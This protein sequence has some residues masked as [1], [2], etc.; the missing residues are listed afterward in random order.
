MAKELVLVWIE[1]SVKFWKG[2]WMDNFTLTR[3]LC[4]GM[5]RMRWSSLLKLN[6]C[7]NTKM[8]IIMNDN[9]G[10][11]TERYWVLCSRV[12]KRCVC[13]VALNDSNAWFG[14][15][16]WF[17]YIAII[18]EEFAYLVCLNSSYYLQN[19]NICT[20]SMSKVCW[21]PLK[22]TRKNEHEFNKNKD[23]TTKMLGPMLN[24]TLNWQLFLGIFVPVLLYIE[25]TFT[26]DRF[27]LHCYSVLFG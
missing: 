11:N 26:G 8:I 20:T 9:F 16:Y 5:K 7:I 19:S 14:L 6:L 13:L 17:T 23:Q 1:L 3:Q 4:S 15:V 18:T 21:K 25:W 12:V 10:L 27:T 2:W 24:Q 22:E